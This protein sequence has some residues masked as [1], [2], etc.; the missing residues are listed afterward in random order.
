MQ[1]DH[2]ERG[3][4]DQVMERYECSSRSWLDE[5]YRVLYRICLENEEVTANL[6]WPHIDF[7]APPSDGRAFGKVMRV[8]LRR[9]WIAKAKG[10]DGVWR[11]Y[12]HLDLPVVRS[13]DGVVIRQKALIPI[14]DSL[15]MGDHPL[16]P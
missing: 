3:R 15:I 16:A 6:V 14:Y 10:S 8:A 7:P 1:T 9:K 5:A 12:D 4:L 2:K 13:R 11:A